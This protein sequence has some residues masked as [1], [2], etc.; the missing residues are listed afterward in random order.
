MTKLSILHI[1]SDTDPVTEKLI[2]FVA[3][4]YATL[5]TNNSG[6]ILDIL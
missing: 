6:C 2:V 4:L 5:I 3:T 1:V